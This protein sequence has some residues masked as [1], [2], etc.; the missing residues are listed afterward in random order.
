MYK[1][2]INNKNYSK[3]VQ[4]N[5]IIYDE[6]IDSVGG[7]YCFNK[8]GEF[9]RY[10]FYHSANSYLYEENNIDKLSINPIINYKFYGNGNEI[11]VKIFY[12]LLNKKIKELKL[13]KDGKV[14]EIR[15]FKEDRFSNVYYSDILLTKYDSSNIKNIDLKLIADI[16]YCDGK[17]EHIE[18]QL[19]CRK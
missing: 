17:V 3:Y 13:F 8:E 9:L 19:T 6:R 15:F 16:E 4:D 18:E 12:F 10:R 5:E 1:E 14:K 11:S 7:V 2:N